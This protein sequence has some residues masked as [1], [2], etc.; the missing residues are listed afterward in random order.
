MRYRYRAQNKMWVGVVC[1]L[2]IHGCTVGGDDAHNGAHDDILK[3]LERLEQQCGSSCQPRH[4]RSTHD[5][6]DVLEHLPGHAEALKQPQQAVFMAPPHGVSKEGGNIDTSE[7]QRQLHM[8][9]SMIHD[10]SAQFKNDHS[11]LQ[12]KN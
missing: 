6:D 9:I 12:V 5:D 11:R 2:L 7:F 10:Q 1:L 4:K 3:R 8:A